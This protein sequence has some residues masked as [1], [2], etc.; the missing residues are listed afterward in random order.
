M[1]Q[2]LTQFCE[3]CMNFMFLH[4]L[5]TERPIPGPSELDHWRGSYTFQRFGGAIAPMLVLSAGRP[6]RLLLGVTDPGVVGVKIRDEILYSASRYP[7]IG[8]GIKK[9][10]RTKRLRGCLQMRSGHSPRSVRT[11]TMMMMV[12]VRFVYL[13][14]RMNSRIG[15][16]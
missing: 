9:G 12:E 4:G 8:D 11:A 10:W 2:N 6:S 14:L 5:F 3:F 15:P 1:T 13:R 16:S 7:C